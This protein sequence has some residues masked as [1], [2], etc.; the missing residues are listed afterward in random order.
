[1]TE[2]ELFPIKETGGRLPNVR[3][4]A[5]VSYTKQI[6]VCSKKFFLFYRDTYHKF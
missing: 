5:V 4:A 2:E 3:D 1:M 6:I